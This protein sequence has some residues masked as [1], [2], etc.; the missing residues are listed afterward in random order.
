MNPKPKNGKNKTVERYIRFPPAQQQSSI[1][2][3][4]AMLPHQGTLLLAA[5]FPNPKAL[6]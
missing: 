1:V 5:T 2:Q 6:S 3:G 4:D